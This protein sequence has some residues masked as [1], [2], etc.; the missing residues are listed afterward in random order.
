LHALKQFS[1]LIKVCCKC[2]LSDRGAPLLPAI[3]GQ[4]WLS[5]ILPA[6]C[7]TH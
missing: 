5:T 7:S 4:S 6:Q 3:C 1:G 2:A